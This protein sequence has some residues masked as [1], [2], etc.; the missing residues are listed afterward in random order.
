MYL[1]GITT[2]YCATVGTIWLGHAGE[3]PPGLWSA[4]AHRSHVN[5]A[6]LARP[7]EPGLCT[8]HGVVDEKYWTQLAD[9]LHISAIHKSNPMIQRARHNQKREPMTANDAQRDIV[10]R[11]YLSQYGNDDDVCG[12][13]GAIPVVKDNQ[14]V[15]GL[16]TDRDICVAVALEQR[17][18][19]CARA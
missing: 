19:E 7:A 16:I 3:R 13:C 12:D 9:H 18:G 8:N 5:Y 14:N 1:L 10:Q 11:R 6:T 4:A 15:I 17:A 2:G